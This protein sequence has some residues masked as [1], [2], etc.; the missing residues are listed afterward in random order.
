M[1]VEDEAM[2]DKYEKEIEELLAGLGDLSPRESRSGRLTRSLRR[3]QY[4]WQ[5]FVLSVSKKRLRPDQLMLTGILLVVATY[6]LRFGLPM[7][8]KYTAI[9]GILLFFAGFVLALKGGNY[10]GPSDRR[11]RGRL[12]SYEEDGLKRIKEWLRKWVR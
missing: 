3:W 1:A 8:A 10:H 5:N 4:S 12:V 2:A 6:F 9:L 11:W 7:V